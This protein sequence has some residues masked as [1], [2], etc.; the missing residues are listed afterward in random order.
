VTVEAQDG[1]QVSGGFEEMARVGVAKAVRP[2]A[3]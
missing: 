1:E 2:T 3:P